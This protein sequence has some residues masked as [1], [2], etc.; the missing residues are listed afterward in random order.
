[1]MIE[2]AADARG[3]PVVQS[4]GISPPCSCARIIRSLWLPS[5]R[6]AGL[7]YRAWYVPKPASSRTRLVTGD[8]QVACWTCDGWKR[9]RPL[10][11]GVVVAVP[12]PTLLEALHCSD[13]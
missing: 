5:L 6:G 13:Q 11:S 10:A 4:A 12:P 8:D 3:H 9:L 7:R 2:A 1:M